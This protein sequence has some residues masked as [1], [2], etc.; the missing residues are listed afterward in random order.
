M[1]DNCFGKYKSNCA[2]IDC[3]IEKLRRCKQYTEYVAEI[4]RIQ[5][6]THEKR[7]KLERKA[8]NVVR[9]ILHVFHS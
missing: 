5:T 6:E 4:D 7:L 3:D 8:D 9:K 1:T 2:C